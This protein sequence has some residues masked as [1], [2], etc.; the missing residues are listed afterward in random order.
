MARWLT[1]QCL[2]VGVASHP[3]RLPFLLHLLRQTSKFDGHWKRPVT[4]SNTHEF[5]VSQAASCRLRVTVLADT[6]SKQHQVVLTSLMVGTLSMTNNAP[7]E[8][9]GAL[10]AV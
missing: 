5:Q 10:H 8:L 9:Q 7:D 4:L 3:A 2:L 1:A 6:K